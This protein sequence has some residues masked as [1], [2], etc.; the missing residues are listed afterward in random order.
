M[1]L[2]LSS[3]A[4]IDAISDWKAGEAYVCNNELCPLLPAAAAGD[5]AAEAEDFVSELR[6]GAA[7]DAEAG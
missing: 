6:R 3:S 7:L 2:T 5:E 1:D 4:S